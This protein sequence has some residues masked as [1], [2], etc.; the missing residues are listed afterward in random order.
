MPEMLEVDELL[1]EVR[2]SERR[3]TLSLIVDRDGQLV[4]HVPS[5]LETDLIHAAVKSKKQWIYTHLIDKEKKLVSTPQPKEYVSGEGFFY[6]GRS[7]R[8]QIVQPNP[9]Q[10]RTP[11][12]RLA[13]GQ[14]FLREDE[15]LN[16][17]KHFIA[18]YT[19]QAK[20][21][22]TRHAPSFAQRFELTLPTLTISDLGYRWGSCSTSQLNFHWRVIMLPLPVLEYVLVHELAHLIV[23]SHSAQFWDTVERVIPEWRERKSW[24]AENGIIYSV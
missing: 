14:F 5:T 15:R 10:A 3:K 2:R 19:R 23:P 17:R 16:G 6:L 7:Y 9:K 11:I 4:V 24:L 20:V 1:L 8:L 21:W 18:W 12:L 22:L 13:R